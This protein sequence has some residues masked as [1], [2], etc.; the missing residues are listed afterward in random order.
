[1]LVLTPIW[2]CRSYLSL[3]VSWCFEPSQA[4]GVTSGLN[5]T[6]NQSLSYS[7]HKSLNID[8]N[9]STP[10]LFQTY[11]HT[12]DRTT[13]STT[14]AWSD[15]RAIVLTTKNTKEEGNEYK[16]FTYFTVRKRNWISKSGLLLYLMQW[17]RHPLKL[18]QTLQEIIQELICRS[19]FPVDSL[20]HVVN[21]PN[22]SLTATPSPSSGETET[23]RLLMCFNG[24]LINNTLDTQCIGS[25]WTG[26]FCK[27]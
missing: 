16:L 11:T 7:A 3:L 14:K 23:E 1:M 17:S 10:Q 15:K 12:S 18:T 24:A 9:I 4:L 13:K 25:A 22:N 20:W 5:T 27:G 2:K 21:T 26:T 6:S 19:L 8:H